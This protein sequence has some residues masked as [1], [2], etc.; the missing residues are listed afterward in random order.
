MREKRNVLLAL[1]YYDHRF[2]MGVAHYAR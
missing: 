2:H 1:G